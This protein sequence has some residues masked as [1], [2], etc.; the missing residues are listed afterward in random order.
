MSTVDVLGVKLR[1]RQTLQCSCK[2]NHRLLCF[3][4][5]ARLERIGKPDGGRHAHE[6]GNG[7]RGGGKEGSG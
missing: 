6:R 2:R 4:I 1:A 7:T 5:K 3:A